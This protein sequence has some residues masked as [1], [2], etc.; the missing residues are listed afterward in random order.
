MLF[1]FRKKKDDF[2]YLP[3]SDKS[4]SDLAQDRF[5]IPSLSHTLSGK[6]FLREELP[7]KSHQLE[8][9]QQEQFIQTIPS[10]TTNPNHCRRCGNTQTS[11]FGEIPCAR[12]NSTHIYCRNCIEMGRVLQCEELYYWTGPKP[13]YSIPNEICAWE[14]KL[15]GAQQLAA[16][17]ICQ[18]IDQAKE[19]LLCWAVCGAGK[20]E[21]LFPAITK[22]I[23]AGKR[24]CLATPRAD[25]VRELFP[26]FQQ[27]FPH[28][29]ITALYGGAEKRD[30]PSQLTLAT[31]HQLIRFADA[32]DVM[33]IDEID[34]FPYHADPL[35]PYVTKRAATK[36]AAFIYLT[37]TPRKELKLRS[38]NGK[39]PTVFVPIRYH[40]QP[41][42]EPQFIISLNLKNTLENYGLPKTFWNWYHN[43]TQANRQLLIFVPTVD[44]S[45]QLSQ[46]LQKQLPGQN[47]AA[48]HADDSEREEKI[49]QFRNKQLFILFSTTILERGVTFPSVDVVV[50]DA[51][52][53]VFDQAALVQIAGRAGRSADDPTG[54]VIFIHDGKTNAMI[55]AKRMISQMNQ[56]A[57]K[58]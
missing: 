7:L 38:D 8:T 26:R 17:R 23:I 35:L 49:Q 42:P 44:H 2:S 30:A 54:D 13:T 21:M 58:L 43:R 55:D 28:I 36:Q 45:N 27:A 39:L 48:V 46:T 34:A 40:G 16:D 33:I 25:V 24:I 19:E 12:C 6:L 56:K 29:T 4:L 37:A 15:T 41:L 57:R 9:L 47:I 11:L 31:T 1:S 18:T 52:H 51:G 53:D 3:S 14:G 5:D 10:I 22:A 32:F 50:L 20:T